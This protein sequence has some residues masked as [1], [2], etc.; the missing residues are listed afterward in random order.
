MASDLELQPRSEEDQFVAVFTTGR[1]LRFNTALDALRQ[2]KIPVQAEEESGTGLKLSMPV[3]PT[4]GPGVFWSL[5]VPEKAVRE[6]ERVLSELPF[7]I[8]TKPGAWDFLP[9][10]ESA[11]A[12]ADATAAKWILT[13]G[14]LAIPL[15]I[16]AIGATM[17]A[18]GQDRVDAIGAIGIGLVLAGIILGLVW[19]SRRWSRRHKTPK[20]SDRQVR[21]DRR[22]G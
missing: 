4:Q 8:T 1:I 15:F 13:I 3:V 21:A 22:G 18:R 2:A 10:S 9:D 16:I 14:F 5:L 19:Y 20:E 17:L 11:E 12:R 6:A 7:P